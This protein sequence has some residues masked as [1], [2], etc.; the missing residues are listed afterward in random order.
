[1]HLIQVLLK[2]ALKRRFL[3]F[4]Q[5]SKDNKGREKSNQ[6]RTVSVNSLG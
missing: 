5:I 2:E 6:R 4:C 3:A 1:M